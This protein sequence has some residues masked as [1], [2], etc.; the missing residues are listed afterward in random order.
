LKIINGEP[1]RV[2]EQEEVRKAFLEMN[3]ITY[4]SN[5]D[6]KHSINRETFISSLGDENKSPPCSFNDQIR[7][8]IEAS[9]EYDCSMNL[10]QLHEEYVFDVSCKGTLPVALSCV[11]QADSFE[12]TMRN[13]LYVG[14][15]SD[16]L[17]AIAGSIAEPLFGVPQ[18]MRDKAESMLAEASLS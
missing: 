8:L 15:D 1:E 17:L 16:T 9:F 6:I 12:K 4:L 11:L 18:Y 13:G 7:E 10:D 3:Y 14:G 5:K 2:S